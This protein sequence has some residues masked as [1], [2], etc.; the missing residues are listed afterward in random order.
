MIFNKELRLFFRYRQGI[1][2]SAMISFPYILNAQYSANTLYS[3]YGIGDIKSSGPIRTSAMGG[4]SIALP[5]EN[6]INNL[7]PASLNEYDSTTFILSA[8]VSGYLSSIQSRSTSETS[9]DLNFNHFAIGFPI[10]RWWGSALGA[11]PFSSVGYNISITLPVEG[12]IQDIEKQFTGT[13]GVSRFYM[14]NT[15][16]LFKQLSLGINVSYLMGTITQTEINKLAIFDY[17]DISIIQSRYY[18]NFYY[19]LGLQFKHKF[20]DDR[21]SLGVTCSPQQKL[22]SRYDVKIM[23]PDI[24]TI[25]TEPDNKHE[26][27]MPL[28]IGAGVAYNINSSLE[29]AFD[30]GFQN[31]SDIQLNSTGA[32]FTDSYHYN[33]GVEYL[34]A[35]KLTRNFFRLIRYRMGGYYESTYLEMRGNTIRDR[36]ITLGAGIPIGRQG[37]SIDI[38]FGIGRLGSLNNGL[39]QKNYGAIKVGFN[40]RDYWFIKRRFD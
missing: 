21:L 23:I 3:F 28:S 4:A 8:G 37:S 15:F 16:R 19:E 29:F 13:G 22:K 33:F 14:M 24:D 9:G 6:F 30:Y 5:S 39:M 18:R 12:T 38:A 36:G 32:R 20:G 10:T 27:I 31:W 25:T 17:S 2:I 35:Q 7:N 1:I 11:V 34:P 26:F 40:L